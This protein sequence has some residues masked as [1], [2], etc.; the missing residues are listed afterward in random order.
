MRILVLTLVIVSFLNSCSMEPGNMLSK[1]QFRITNSS[2][3]PVYCYPS[4]EGD[5]RELDTVIN[6]IE[7]TM[8][9]YELQEIPCDSTVVLNGSGNWYDIINGEDDDGPE[10]TLF[11]FEKRCLDS[12]DWNKSIEKNGGF[13][14]YKFSAS[15]IESIKFHLVVK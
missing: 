4:I 7:T 9:F 5:I 1:D 10:V 3:M 14:K 6:H 12:L 11:V 13:R 2:G 15:D 8:H